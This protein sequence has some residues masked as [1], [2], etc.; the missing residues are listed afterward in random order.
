VILAGVRSFELGQCEYIERAGIRCY[1]VDGLETAL[2]GLA[3][4]VYVHIDLDVTIPRLQLPL[5][6]RADRGAA[7]TVIELVARVDNIIGA[8]IS[9]HAPADERDAPRAMRT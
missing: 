6:P 1:G 3:G 2:D 5:L 9:E 7:G 4:P 8:S